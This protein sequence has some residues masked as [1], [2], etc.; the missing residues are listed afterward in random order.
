ME[1]RKDE[2]YLLQSIK[3]INKKKINT[4][5]RKRINIK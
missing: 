1:E 3:I 2:K 5:V 4:K